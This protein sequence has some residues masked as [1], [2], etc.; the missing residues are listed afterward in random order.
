MLL[1]WVNSAVMYLPAPGLSPCPH[2]FLAYLLGFWVPS[3]SE[4]SSFSIFL[5]TK[6]WGHPFPHETPSLPA[7]LT[8][9]SGHLWAE[10][11]VEWLVLHPLYW[12]RNQSTK[13]WSALSVVTGEPW[14]SLWPFLVFL[15]LGQAPRTCEAKKWGSE[16]EG[17]RAT[18]RMDQ[19]QMAGCWSLSAV[20][21]GQRLIRDRCS[22]SYQPALYQEQSHKYIFSLGLRVMIWKLSSLKPGTSTPNWLPFEEGSRDSCWGPA[23]TVSSSWNGHPRAAVPRSCLLLSLWSILSPWHR[24]W[25]G[26]GGSPAEAVCLLLWSHH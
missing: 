9:S 3:V 8:E 1:Y 10:G 23:R 17:P 26:E 6:E 25:P 22:S 14:V 19:S 20:T 4:T 2:V 11:K 12:W 15:A 21:D 16:P 13:M 18:L 7:A 5:F 24:C